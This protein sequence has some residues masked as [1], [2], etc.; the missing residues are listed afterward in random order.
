MPI[1]QCSRHFANC[2]VVLST[3][4]VFKYKGPPAKRSGSSGGPRITVYF[5]NE[6][7]FNLDAVSSDFF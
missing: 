7:I 3:D 5:F 1:S 6:Q 2:V 4:F